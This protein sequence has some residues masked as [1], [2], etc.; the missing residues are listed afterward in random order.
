MVAP[1]F[2]RT[3]GTV[4]RSHGFRRVR[5]VRARKTSFGEARSSGVEVS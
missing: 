4:R 1:P 5:F 2:S 3:S